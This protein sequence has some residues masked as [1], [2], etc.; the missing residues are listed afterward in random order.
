MVCERVESLEAIYAAALKNPY[1]M[2][3]RGSPL[4]T[5]PLPEMPQAYIPKVYV[6]ICKET[7][8]KARRRCWNGRTGVVLA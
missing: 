5:A 2:R 7:T 8:L 6:V 3:N 1:C 4:A